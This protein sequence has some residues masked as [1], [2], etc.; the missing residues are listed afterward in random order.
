MKRRNRKKRRREKQDQKKK[1]KIIYI[2]SSRKLLQ[3]TPWN[4]KPI[5]KGKINKKLSPKQEGKSQNITQTFSSLI[6]KMSN[7]TEKFA[8]QVGRLICQVDLPLNSG[9][10]LKA[11]FYTK[12]QHAY[13]RKIDWICRIFL[14]TMALNCYFNHNSY[15]VF[16]YKSKLIFLYIND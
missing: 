10:W 13:K 12:R 2:Y 8:V 1:L 15:K 14:Q 16:L 9:Q 7:R 3:L 11:S 6:E 4:W 5:S